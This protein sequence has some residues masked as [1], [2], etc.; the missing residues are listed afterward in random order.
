VPKC[1]VLTP[2]SSGDQIDLQILKR[3]LCHSGVSPLVGF[4][5]SQQQINLIRRFFSNAQTPHL[6]IPH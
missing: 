2:E 5:V 3:Y 6:A 1:G 4:D